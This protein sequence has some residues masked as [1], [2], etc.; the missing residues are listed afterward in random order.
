MTEEDYEM[1]NKMGDNMKENVSRSSGVYNE[2][3]SD[4]STKK[5]D[6]TRST[7][8]KNRAIERR[9]FMEDKAYEIAEG[10]EGLE[11]V[12]AAY[13]IK[14]SENVHANKIAEGQKGLRGVIAAYTIR[15]SDNVHAD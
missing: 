4:N 7:S 1:Y 6:S 9:L 5:S 2:A 15:N 10:E 14:N 12:M 13:A 11:R 8:S 3:L